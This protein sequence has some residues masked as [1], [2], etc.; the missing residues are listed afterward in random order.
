MPEQVLVVTRLL[1]S[2]NS[3]NPF[4]TS[5]FRPR[6]TVHTKVM[7]FERRLSPTSAPALR[8]WPP[9]AA[10]LSAVPNHSRNSAAGT[11]SDS[12]LPILP[13]PSI[14]RR[15]QYSISGPSAVTGCPFPPAARRL[16]LNS[17]FLR[18]F[19]LF[20][21]PVPVHLVAAVHG[22]PSLISTHIAH[23]HVDAVESEVASLSI[24]ALLARYEKSV[25]TF[26]P[27]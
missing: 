11:L 2:Y 15:T 16:H 10:G 23:R 19:F 18:K 13:P 26:A 27:A 6:C 24:Y 1:H 17:A 22:P 5:L 9:L 8:Y 12:T 3:L 14:M 25:P 20:L 21:T 4:A 7:Y